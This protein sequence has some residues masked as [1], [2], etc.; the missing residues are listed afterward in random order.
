MSKQ[1]WLDAAEVF[2]AWRVVPRLVL[3]AYCWWLAYVVDYIL[4]WYT[5][6]PA[7]A[8]SIEASGMASVVITAVTGMGAFVF[9]VYVSGGRSWD[10]PSVTLTSTKTQ[11]TQT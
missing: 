11:V 7:P 5:R 6:L 3:F 4:I 10:Q 9:K 8:R 1:H 2:D